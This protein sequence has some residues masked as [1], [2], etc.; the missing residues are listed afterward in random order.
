MRIG[1]IYRYARPYSASQAKIDGLPNY[2]FES[3]SPNCTLALMEKG[4]NAVAPVA[5]AEG[6]R[7][8]AIIIR[9]S[10]HKIGSHET[11]WQDVFDV[12]N[13]HIRYYGDN[14]LPGMDPA[15]A[16]GNRIL[17]EAFN[18]QTSSEKRIREQ[19]VPLI[20][21][22]TVT[23]KGT[24][25]GYVQFQGFGVIRGVELVTQYDRKKDQTFSNY[26][27]DFTV[28]SLAKNH[29]EFDWAWISARRDGR[30]SLVD[31]LRH[32]PKSWQEW[33]QYGARSLEKNRRR[34]SKLMTYTTAE[35]KPPDGS[36][37]LK[38][39]K[40]VYAFY[41]NNRARFETLAAVVAGR[42]MGANGGRF[43]LGWITPPSADEGSDFVGRVDIGSGFAKAKLVVL[44]QAKCEKMN[45]ATGGNHVARTVARLKRGWVGVYVTTSF[46]SEAVQREVIEDQYP[47]LLVHGYRLAQELLAMMH[48]EGFHDIDELLRHIDLKHD[49]L[50]KQ[51]KPEEI[52]L[53]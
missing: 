48:D 32:A 35:Q 34:V 20:F 15:T 42:V 8:P 53:D 6:L 37:E 27:F 13:G 43:R 14:K 45:S 49:D 19:A 10:P 12:D 31:S 4:I 44:G 30:Q 17:I 51:R 1:T 40:S 16:P 2:F 11:P 28:M 39:L 18:M 47:V 50:V 22:R 46:F 33:I 5:S 26:A 52:L 9:S 7:R 21:F 3:N 38:I 29:E 36:M 41:Q 25:K 23:Y 24:A